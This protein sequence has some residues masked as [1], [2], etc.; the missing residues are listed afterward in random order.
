MFA[1]V[2][3]DSS[4]A[5]CSDSIPT[6]H[7]DDKRQVCTETRPCVY[8]LSHCFNQ[9]IYQPHDTLQCSC[10]WKSSAN[11]VHFYEMKWNVHTCFCAVGTNFPNN[12]T[13]RI[14]LFMWLFLETWYIFTKWRFL[15]LNSK[16]QYA[17]RWSAWW[18]FSCDRVKLIFVIG[19]AYTYT[20]GFSC[21]PW[22]PF[23]PGTSQQ[24]RCT[25]GEYNPMV[26]NE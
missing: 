26:P 3:S 25:N 5:R 22:G 15:S 8:V 18:Q 21:V 16:W 19:N 9:H 13:L 12:R 20:R 23:K 11:Y 24:E 10:Q 1:E 6:A 4:R 17:G 14:H 2:H 7:C